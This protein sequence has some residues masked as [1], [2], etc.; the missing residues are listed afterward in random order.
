MGN[1][2]FLMGVFL[3]LGSIPGAWFGAR[4]AQRVPELYLKKFFA[5]FLIGVGIMLFA[6]ELL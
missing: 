1:V 5:I 2:A 6:H 4:L 3:L